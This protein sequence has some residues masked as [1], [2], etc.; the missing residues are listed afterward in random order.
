MSDIMERIDARTHKTK[1]C[2]EWQGSTTPKGYGKLRVGAT[3]KYVHRLVWSAQH[4]RDPPRGACVCHRCDNPRCVRPSHLFLGSNA[5]NLAD[6]RRKNR[7]A[8]GERVARAV[9]TQ[10]QAQAVVD[11][12]AKKKNRDVW[13]TQTRFAKRWAAR[14][15]VSWHAVKHVVQRRTWRHLSE[16]E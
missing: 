9:L 16:R 3:T 15:G 13:G 5:E 8:K 7:Q 14:L 11:A 10:E 6:M 4:G 1:T 2:W 12:W